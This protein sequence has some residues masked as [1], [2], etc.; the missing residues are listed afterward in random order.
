MYSR[1][2]GG[3]RGR[4]ERRMRQSLRSGW[5]I[6]LAA[7]IGIVC[8][9][10]LGVVG[11]WKYATGVPPFTPQLPPLP[12]PNGYERAAKAAGR[13][14]RAKGPRLPA[15]WPNGTQAELHAQLAP[16][17]PVLDEI[18]A[19]FRLDWRAPPELGLAGIGSS[20]P[21]YAGFRECARCFAAET[22][23][24]RRQ[25]DY[26][27]AM[28][29]SLDSMELGAKLP[30]GGA[31]ITRLVGRA[32]HGLG[33]S[34]VERIVPQ[35]PA[36]AIPNALDRVR[37]V[38]MEWPPMSETWE[39]ARVQTLSMWTD[40]FVDLQRQPLREQF[41]NLRSLQEQPTLLGTVQLALTPRRVTLANLERYYQRRI[42]E[43]KKPFRQ[44]VPAHSGPWSGESD[45]VDEPE[46]SWK[47]EFA[48]TELAILEVA[49]A[50]QLYRL[51]HGRCPADLRA[52]GRRWLP[53]VPADQWDQPIAYRL[54]GGKPSIYS[55][56]PD[57]KDDGGL[58]ANVRHLGKTARGDLVFGRLNFGA[59]RN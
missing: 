44:R 14:W 47:L 23:V 55:L 52:I 10:A 33:F 35:L 29:R 18:R 15:R 58:A 32:C 17:R 51:E 16:L 31:L 25:G 46:H 3:V 49:L 4:G 6:T 21:N 50:V 20:I 7:G 43:S 56:G 39:S 34:Q 8:A 13:L 26:S 37:R 42:A 59:W 57:G 5:L 36:V 45:P 19:T 2:A 38:R 48:Q 30:R 12:K 28:Q 40:L 24:A 53:V 22:N 9:L 1:S 11:Y 54:R 41:D 27:T